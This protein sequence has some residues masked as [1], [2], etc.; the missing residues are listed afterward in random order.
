M[1]R[2]GILGCAEIA[3]RR[4][5]PAVKEVE[6]I[7]PVVVA[8]EYA[9]DKLAAFKDEYGLETSESFDEVIAREDIDAL[10]IPQPPALHFK[11]ALKALEHGKHVLVEKPSTT[12]YEDTQKLVT[13]ASEKALALHE[14]YMFSYHKQVDTIRQLVAEGRVG[15]LRLI[16]E[17]FCFP[18]RA[19]NDFRYNKELGGGALLDAAGYPV[20]LATLLLG[21]EIKIDAAKLNYLPEFSVDMFG[22][23]S[24]SDNNG[25]VCQLTFGMDC[26]Y[27]CTVEVIGSKGRIFTDRIF[28]APPDFEP[29]LQLQNGAEKQE[30]K[31]EKDN[32]F[33]HSI[34]AFIN[35]IND[36]SART[37]MYEAILTQS[38]LIEDIRTF[39]EKSGS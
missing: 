37:N 22:S 8:E 19:V 9:K 32:H 18:R 25:T 36:G 26:Q 12:N 13:L 21:D 34:E 16:R 15:D 20:K 17:A 28:T 23:A 5:M 1:I 24:L 11:W 38:R 2:L 35:E 14:N 7:I 29:V 30:I 33:K 31:V 4:F 39:G 3:Y 10:Y 27:Q 6:G